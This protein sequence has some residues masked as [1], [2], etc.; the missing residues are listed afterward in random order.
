MN[1]EGVNIFGYCERQGKTPAQ[2]SALAIKLTMY[3]L[4]EFHTRRTRHV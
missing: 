2:F 1:M 4:S 3:N